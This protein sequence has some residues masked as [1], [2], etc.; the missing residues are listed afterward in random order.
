MID[1]RLKKINVNVPGWESD[2]S[3][4]LDEMLIKYQ[5]LKDDCI[6][7]YIIN[8]PHPVNIQGSFK[9]FKDDVLEIYK[10]YPWLM[11]TEQYEIMTKGKEV[12]SNM[13]RVTAFQI[14]FYFDF[15]DNVTLEDIENEL[16]AGQYEMHD[17]MLEVYN[18]NF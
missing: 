12:L 15:E 8:T 17:A 13:V 11:V 7:D 2:L 5:N 6:W 18:S 10:F 9:E 4:I 3:D 1:K 16:R 14:R